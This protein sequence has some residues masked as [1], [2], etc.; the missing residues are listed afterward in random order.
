MHTPIRTIQSKRHKIVTMIAGGLLLL[1]LGAA[2]RAQAACAPITVSLTAVQQLSFES[3]TSGAHQMKVI[4]VKITTQDILNLIAAAQVT[5]TTFPSGSLLCYE[6]DSDPLRVRDKSNALLFEI[7]PGLLSLQLS[8][9]IYSKNENPLKGNFS[10]AGWALATFKFYLTDPMVANRLKLETNGLVSLKGSQKS[11]ATGI[12]A[13]LSI[14]AAGTGDLFKSTITSTNLHPAGDPDSEDGDP[15][16]I[17]SGTIALKG[18][19]PT[20]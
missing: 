3:Y 12:Q 15:V 11:P 10:S 18:T 1:A 7:A 16:S 2:S 17:V 8:D 9:K 6:S 14:K 20:L 13:T 4:K 5:P 19:L